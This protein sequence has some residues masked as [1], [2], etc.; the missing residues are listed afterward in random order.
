MTDEELSR[1]LFARKFD[2]ER[3]A[4][5][6]ASWRQM[7]V[8]HG[9]RFGSIRY[10]DIERELRFAK[11]TFFGTRDYNGAALISFKSVFHDPRT[12]KKEDVF[13]LLMFLIDLALRDVETQ[14]HG[15]AMVLDARGMRW[16]NVDVDME[17]LVMASLDRLPVRVRAIYVVHPP[18]VMK[19]M[20]A[21][22]KPFMKPKMRKRMRFIKD[23]NNLDEFIP[24]REALPR[25][26]GG[27]LAFD[28]YGWL[29]KFQ[30]GSLLVP[31][32]C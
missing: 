17:K 11:A 8:D 4:E 25:D 19:A 14:R 32:A 27:R 20:I 2:T 18:V 30:A 22:M 12:S 1:C 15:I 6:F 31:P 9:F 5:L 24:A 10:G 28:Y 3:A 21:L 7:Q 13:R 29:D 26:L 23:V 16:K